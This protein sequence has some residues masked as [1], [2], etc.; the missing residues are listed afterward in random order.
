MR[1]KVQV[2]VSMCGLSIDTDSNCP[3]LS[4]YQGVKKGNLAIVLSFNGEG[5][6]KDTL[7]MTNFITH[8]IYHRMIILFTVPCMKT[9][10]VNRSL[11][12]MV[13]TAE[14]Q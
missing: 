13:K 6:L 7:K 10:N 4:C 11:H 3:I 1:V 8:V 12:N 5:Y 14:G 9:G 2:S